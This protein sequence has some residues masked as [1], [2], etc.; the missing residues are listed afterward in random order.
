MT[1]TR[2]HTG[3][4][5][6]QKRAAVEASHWRQWKREGCD[7]ARRKL[8]DIYLP[9]AKR[10]A[11]SEFRE[12]GRA[13]AELGD[14]V[15]LAYVGLLEAMETY[16]PERDAAF[17]GYAH[18]RLLGSISDGLAKSSDDRAAEFGKRKAET[19]RIRAILGS[20]DQD[21]DE[22][23]DQLRSVISDLALGVLA[24]RGI[25]PPPQTP[26]RQEDFEFREL[27][28][29]VVQ[30]IEKMDDPDRF[31]MRRHYFDEVSLGTLAEALNVTASRVSQI[32][33]R[34]LKQLRAVLGIG[35]KDRP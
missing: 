7:E 12:R 25:A 13:G 17:I 15:Q 35:T 24:K 5:L 29:S 32:H 20:I 18:A 21:E 10:I 31:V 27:C 8:F 34:S 9:W 26:V 23:L 19:E 28:I 2:S 4:A 22:P 30:A 33:S 16:Q 6:L 14:I 3:Q 11:G 1:V